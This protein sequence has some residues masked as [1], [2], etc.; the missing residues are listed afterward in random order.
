M[1]SLFLPGNAPF[2]VAI[3]LMI[4]IGLLEGIALLIGFSITEHAGS[5][6]VAHFGVDHADAGAETGVVGQFLGWLHIGRV[7]LLI[8]LTLFLLGFAIL[9]LVLQTVLQSLGGFTLPPAVAAVLAALG[10]LPFVRQTGGLIA[11]M[12]PQ[13]ESSAV[14]E[15]DFI[16]RAAQIVTGEAAAGNPAEAR[17]VDEFGQPHYVR[18]EPDDAGQV[19]PRGTSVLIVSRVSGSVYRVIENPRPDLL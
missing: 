5:L 18:V 2:V 14:S 15:I 4:A 9:G 13:S 7:P 11:R 17:F 19:F 12:L 8:L 6:L 3:A 10:A 1:T 16:G